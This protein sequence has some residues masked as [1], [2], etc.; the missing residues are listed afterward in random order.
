MVKVGIS[1]FVNEKKY[2]NLKRT[3]QILPK[4]GTQ[5]IKFTNNEKPI[6]KVVI[7]GSGNSVSHS[8]SKIITHYKDQR[9]KFIENNKINYTN[10]YCKNEASWEHIY[11]TYWND[12][13][14]GNRH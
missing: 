2:R 5:I 4:T 11:C 1:R 10:Y 14:M 8:I 12:I 7:P 9:P 3:V 13:I 6:T